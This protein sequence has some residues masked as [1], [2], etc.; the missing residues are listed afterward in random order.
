MSLKKVQV[1]LTRAG[2]LQSRVPTGVS[3]LQ[4]AEHDMMG[5]QASTGPTFVA[6]LWPWQVLAVGAGR[7]QGLTK[8]MTVTCS[9]GRRIPYPHPLSPLGP[10]LRVMGVLVQDAGWGP[11]PRAPEFSSPAPLSMG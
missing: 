9:P 10:G 11:C 1:F 4:G 2:T 3:G 8:G 5:I 6:T 7:H